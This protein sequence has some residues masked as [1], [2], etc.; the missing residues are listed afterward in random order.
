MPSEDIHYKSINPDQGYDRDNFVQHYENFSDINGWLGILS[1][2]TE[3]I[4][5]RK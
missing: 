3:N 4:D 1:K 2:D 5:V